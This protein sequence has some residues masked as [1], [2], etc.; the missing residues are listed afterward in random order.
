MDPR[1]QTAVSDSEVTSTIS[2]QRLDEWTMLP[3]APTWLHVRLHASLNVI[4]PFAVS[5]RDFIMLAYRSRAFTRRSASPSASACSYARSNS[6]PY[7]SGRL[8]TALGSK[9]DHI[10]SLSTRRMNRSGTQLARFRLCVRRARS[11]VLALRSRNSSMSAC[12]GS[13]Y[14]QQAP[15]RFPP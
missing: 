4:Q 14:T 9:S 1:L 2:V 11:P 5:A 7:N 13:K 3:E 15:C 12:Q 10:P 6:S 8:G